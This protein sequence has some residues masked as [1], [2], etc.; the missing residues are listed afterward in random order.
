MSVNI[1]FLRICLIV[2]LVFRTI[3]PSVF[4]PVV[5]ICPLTVED[6][7]NLHLLAVTQCGVRL[8][9]STTPLLQPTQTN[10]NAMPVDPAKPQSLY[11][12]HVRL[13]P[14]Y[15][16]NTTAG[17]PKNVHNAYYSKGNL[18]M[19]S[20]PQQEQDILWSISSEPFPL[21]PYL[22]ESTTLITL[23]GQV[24][25]VADVIEER[26]NEKVSNVLTIAKNEKK[27]VLLTNQGA[28]VVA[29]KK[30]VHLLQQ[31]LIACHGA[32]HEAVK[33]YFQSQTEPQACATSVLLACMYNGTE[34][35]IWAK[36]AFLLYGGEP[37][38][39]SSN[40]MPDQT[41]PGPRHLNMSGTFL[42]NS[43]V[44]FFWETFF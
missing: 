38:F 33:G 43:N 41:A 37:H 23:N 31:L 6:S 36:Q 40:F 39:Q 5:A 24:W 34:I 32:H 27:V 4:K 42:G 25:G 12:L 3:D 19:M 9:F 30:Q 22:A 21:R 35:G 29:L 11:L 20:T 8:Y 44:N 15:T 17:K 14:G 16:P 18:L 13:P 2:S 26:P 7:L 10:N 1:F 28:H